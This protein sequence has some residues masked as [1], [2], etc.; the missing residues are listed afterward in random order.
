MEKCGARGVRS[1][2][3]Q[4]RLK[5]FQHGESV[6]S[7]RYQRRRGV[8]RSIPVP[9]AVPLLKVSMGGNIGFLVGS[10]SHLGDHSPCSECVHGATSLGGDTT[11][12]PFLVQKFRQYSAHPLLRV[13]GEVVVK[14]NL[15]HKC[16]RYI[17][18]PTHI[19]TPHLL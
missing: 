3:A 16:P 5:G 17:T 14:Y 11:V 19:Y 10:R 12:T 4:R 6:P 13:P 9:L 8:L 7:D 15:R 1:G 2:E 18:V